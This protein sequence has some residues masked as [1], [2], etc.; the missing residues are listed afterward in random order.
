MLNKKFNTRQ[1]LSLN[2]IL[3]SSKK[4]FTFAGQIASINSKTTNG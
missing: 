3:I 2:K 1:E 4:K